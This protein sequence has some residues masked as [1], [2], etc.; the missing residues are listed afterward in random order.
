LLHQLG[1][2]RLTVSSDSA[3]VTR[4]ADGT[5][6]IAVWNYAPPG[7]EGETRTYQ[8]ALRNLAGAHRAYVWWVDR[9]HGSALTAWRAMGGPR[10][11]SI[12]QQRIL[13]QAAELPGPMIEPLAPGKP[14]LTLQLRPH[15]LA[16][17]EIGH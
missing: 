1:S 15:A 14:R 2:Q 5:L 9:D 17:V 10:F 4:R 13:L 11:P 7:P 6:V 3:L 16:L 8:L 12:E